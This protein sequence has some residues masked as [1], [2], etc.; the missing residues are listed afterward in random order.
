ME[1]PSALTAVTNTVLLTLQSN[2]FIDTNTQATA[3]VI[4]VN[5][6]PSVQA[7]SPFAPAATYSTAS[8][9]GSGRFEGYQNYLAVP[10][11][12]LGSGD[13][14]IEAWMY[15]WDISTDFQ[16]IIGNLIGGIGNTGWSLYVNKDGTVKLSGN[17]L[18]YG[19]TVGAIKLN[20]WNHI[21]VTRSG[22]NLRMYI[23]GT[24]DSTTTFSGDLSAANDINVG[25]EASGGAG[26]SSN[27]SYYSGLRVLTGTA[28]YTGATL[29]VPTAPPTAI[30]S[31]SLLLNFTNAGIYDAHASKVIETVGDAKVSTAQS[32][33]AGNSLLFDG[34]GDSLLI[35]AS[36]M[37]SFGTAPFTIEFWVR[38]VSLKNYSGLVGPPNATDS[39]ATGLNLFSAADGSL[40]LTIGN[41]D[42][43]ITTTTGLIVANMWQH[44]VLVRINDTYT[45]YIDGTS[46]GTYTV[47][48]SR[49]L[50][51]TAYVSIGSNTSVGDLNGYIE[52]FRVTKGFARYML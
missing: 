8:H 14:T 24:L 33:F 7:V 11:P 16:V 23:N 46:R 1:Q 6:T 25:R 41:S 32:K 42:V 19:T 10:H 31:T 27:H 49:N 43:Q 52:G 28:L 47:S 39:A 12:A 30:A 18:V 26:W 40:K 38:H 36:P 51:G 35:P 37:L 17:S 21:A 15:S 22:S 9:G 3:K 48:G 13:F 5:G 34:T 4:T 45:L 50:Y 2:R 20:S 29:T 44:V